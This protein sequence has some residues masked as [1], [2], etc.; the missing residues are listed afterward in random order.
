MIK[1]STQTFMHGI[2]G[3][4]CCGPNSFS[5][6]LGYQIECGEEG[7]KYI[8]SLLC[9]LSEYECGASRILKSWLNLSASA[10]RSAV[11]LCPLGGW[12]TA[13]VWSLGVM[14]LQASDSS[15]Q[16]TLGKGGF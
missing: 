5:P 7:D 13:R 6:P 11:W 12:K 10:M 8:P 9:W 16:V 15:H 1:R 3:L 4:A 14:I 2:H